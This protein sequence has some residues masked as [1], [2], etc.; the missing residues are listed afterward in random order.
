MLAILDRKNGALALAEAA[1]GKKLPED[2]VKLGLRA[3]RSTA[4]DE[5]QLVAALSSAGGI[6]GGA[7]S[8]RRPKWA[9]S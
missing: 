7:G 2:A 5:P 3:I 8:S 6:N 4:R 1:R 9:R